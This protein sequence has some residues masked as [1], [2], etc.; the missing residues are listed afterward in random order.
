MRLNFYACALALA[1]LVGDMAVPAPA[2]AAS[3]SCL[4]GVLKQRLSQIRKRFGSI[5]VVSTGRPGAK[6]RGSGKASYHASCR[7]ADFVPPRGK[8]GEV[9]RW[10]YANHEGG[11]GTYTCM[12]HIHIDN[13]PSVRWSKCR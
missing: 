2:A 3:E 13:G 10:L 4:P 5:S 8:Y 12:N 1:L 7:A 11:V 6:I 9:T